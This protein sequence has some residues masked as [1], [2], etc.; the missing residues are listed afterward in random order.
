M[1]CGGDGWEEEEEEGE[2]PEVTPK[3]SHKA[4]LPV[5]GRDEHVGDEVPQEPELPHEGE[6]PTHL[7]A[8]AHAVA[9]E[10][11]AHTPR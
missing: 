2:L 10:G 9:K 4:L 6:A 5:E 11:L 7:A 1:Y 3:V 8:G